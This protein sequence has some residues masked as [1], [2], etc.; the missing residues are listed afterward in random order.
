MDKKHQITLV[1]LAFLAILFTAYAFNKYSASKEV[2]APVEVIEPAPAAAPA[3]P[4][5]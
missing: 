2:A 1:V 4:A 5:K 3:A